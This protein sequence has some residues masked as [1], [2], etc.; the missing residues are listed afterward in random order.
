MGEVRIFETES[1]DYVLGR[2]ERDAEG[3]IVRV[4][5]VPRPL[6]T[7]EEIES[8]TCRTIDDVLPISVLED[9]EV[10]EAKA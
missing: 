2:V 4:E 3:E 8:A 1:M 5:I 7:P 10:T 9:V 6:L